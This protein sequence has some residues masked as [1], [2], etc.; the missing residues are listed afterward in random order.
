LAEHDGCPAHPLDGQAQ[1]HQLELRG[2][3]KR[4][5]DAVALAGI[6]LEIPAG[7]FVTLLGP[8]GSGKTTTL[9]AIAG[10][11][12]PDAGDILMDGK[13]IAALPPH[14]RNLGMVFQSYALFPHM[15]V[16]DNVA[17]PLRQRK[18]RKAQI[19]S[20]VAE[21]L[22]L[23]G[24][25]ELG[26]RYP[27]EL[28]GGQ[29]Q[30]V[31]LARA[32]VFEPRVLL[33]DEPLGALDKRLREGLQ[34]EFKRIHRELGITFLYVTHD[35]D[36]AL[37]MSDRIAVFEGG[38]IEQVGPPAELYERPTS[39]FVAKFLG[40]SNVLPGRVVA[41]GG[42]TVLRTGD[43]ELAVPLS[44][45]VATGEP[46]A[47]VLRPERLRVQASTTDAPS[48]ANVLRG[49]VRQ[50]IYLGDIRRLEVELSDSLRIVVQEQAGA[51]SSAI[52]G[53]EVLV[54]WD[55]DEGVLLP[56]RGELGADGEDLAAS[57]ATAVP[58]DRDADQT[59]STT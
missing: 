15:R 47:L 48:Q 56:E 25:A 6:S 28:S 45:T 49:R 57:G 26:T 54:S 32:L 16:A 44:A 10:F 46:A 29:Q 36:E 30:R 43:Y 58:G 24:L 9:N 41:H 42:R 2:L 14:R 13:P 23:V 51:G 31:A 59:M 12:Q 17:F 18:Q 39:V 21:A 34:L 8:S 50:L 11:V 20:R 40:D 1:A 3:V 37:V 55:P 5:G 4:Y 35:Q 38:R 22:E 33:M 7:E 19:R 52:E 53:D 27:R